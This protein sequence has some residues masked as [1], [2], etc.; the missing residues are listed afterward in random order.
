MA[1]GVELFRLLASLVLNTEEFDDGVEGADKKAKGFFKGFESGITKLSSTMNVL[2]T[3]G[4]TAVDIVK[5]VAQ[6][7]L[8]MVEVA[9]DMQSLEE[10]MASAFEGMEAE[11][12][13]AFE[14]VGEA[15]NIATLRLQKSGL[16]I[17]QQFTT[18]G[19]DSAAALDNMQ[20]TLGLAADAAAKYDISLEDAT[21]RMRS[22]LRGNAEAA[23]SIGLS[24]TEFDRNHL[25][26]TLYDGKKW[27]D[28]TEQ[29]RQFVLLMHAENQYRQGG[30]FGWGAKEAQNWS[31]TVNNLSS[32]WEKAQGIMGKKIMIALIPALEDLTDWIVRNPQVFE[33]IGT[34]FGEIAEALVSAFQSLLTFIDAHG[35]DITKFFDGLAKVFSGEMDLFAF[36]G[37]G[38]NAAPEPIADERGAAQRQAAID[39]LTGEGTYHAMVKAF[40]G[41]NAATEAIRKKYLSDDEEISADVAAQFV[42]DAMANL[43]RE[44]DNANLTADVEVRATG[45]DSLLSLASRGLNALGNWFLGDR[46]SEDQAATYN[47]KGLEYVPYDDY[48]T[49][50]H[51]GESVLNRVEAENWRAAQRGGMMGFDPAALG[52]AV[53]AAL[54]GVTVNIDGHTAG[55]L[56]TPYVSKEQYKETWKRR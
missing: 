48:Y 49:R 32:A 43:Q 1:Q 33:D 28:L 17:F 29:Q 35:E 42:D 39:Y 25:A 51:R 54:A 6:A 24:V 44:I 30:I 47:A 22:F 26:G 19:M 2:G 18:A 7:G 15:N 46:P 20:L 50:L 45:L 14:A 4:G 52:A 37:G 34:I 55:A 16:A 3:V 12:A 27:A 23:D 21:E 9:A 11:A 41:S 10:G 5:G 38:W 40:G 56:L 31:N 53:A 8:S 13:K 36:L